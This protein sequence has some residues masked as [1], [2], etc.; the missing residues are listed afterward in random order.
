MV[1]GVNRLR[2]VAGVA[3]PVDLGSL[4]GCCLRVADL[5]YVS[6]NAISGNL[7][8]TEAAATAPGRSGLHGYD[9]VRA[10]R[11]A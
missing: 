11:V 5:P 2:K 10:W 7:A 9:S 1:G 8:I 4:A 3:L 6:R